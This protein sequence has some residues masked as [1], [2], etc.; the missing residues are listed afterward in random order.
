MSRLS[1]AAEKVKSS[2][3]TLEVLLYK[4]EGDVSA[5]ILEITYLTNILKPKHQK[6]HYFPFKEWTLLHGGRHPFFS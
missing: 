4:V 2:I 1:K 6:P 5:L 3:A